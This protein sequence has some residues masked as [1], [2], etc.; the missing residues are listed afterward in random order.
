MRR[1]PQHREISRPLEN[2]SA[3]ALPRCDPRRWVIVGL[4]LAILGC[5]GAPTAV[6]APAP[7]GARLV[8]E[9][10]P[11][12]DARFRSSELW[13]GGDGALSVALDDE[14][15]LWLFGDSFVVDPTLPSPERPGRAGTVM[16]RNSVA[17]QT[18]RE[19]AS[20]R[21]EFF[22][23]VA[24][25]GRPVALFTGESLSDQFWLWPGH[26]LVARG[27][28]ILFMHKMLPDDAPGGLGFRPAG[29]LALSITQIGLPPPEWVIEHI[30]LP[31]LPSAGLIGA[32][33]LREGPHVYAFGVRDPG[34]RALTL[35][36]WEEVRFE[37]GDLL[38]PEVW[39]GPE[40][41]FVRGGEA[42]AILGPVST[43]LSITPDPR[44][45]YVLIHSDGFGVA[46]IAVRFS[47]ALTGPWSEPTSIDLAPFVGQ[48]SGDTLV[49]AAKAHPEQPGA[50]WIV[51]YAV[52]SL[53]GTRIWSDL[54]IYFPR[55]LRVNR[56]ERGGA[57]EADAAR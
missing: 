30:D 16:V 57:S 44:G 25:R 33:V 12:A 55:V 36:R 5:A 50:D 39:S 37:R 9:P 3:T 11:E 17:I 54:S 43:E 4:A 31:Q 18:G 40:H 19:L 38:E 34:D 29:A 23:G 7:R 8:A 42:A 24:E 41:G 48:P 28:L 46:P 45:G 56:A 49:Y 6:E 20:A 10:W 13:L 51:T 15:T 22:T 32:A 1:H 2:T 53:D 21:L 26:G 14:R 35:V 52:N 27:R 47:P